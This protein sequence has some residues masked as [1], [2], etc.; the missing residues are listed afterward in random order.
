[1]IDYII[2]MNYEIDLDIDEIVYFEIP[3]HWR[4]DKFINIV[5]LAFVTSIN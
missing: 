1:M 2:D 3:D 4:V 5:L